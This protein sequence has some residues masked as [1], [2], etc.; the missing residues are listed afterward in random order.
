MNGQKWIS[1]TDRN[2][3]ERGFGAVDSY[4]MPARSVA[5]SCIGSDMGKAAL[6][7]N[8]SVTNQQINTILV[9]ESKFNAEFVFTISL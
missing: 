1:E 8:P 3:N 6:L 2:L 9:D 4:L 7:T 5:V